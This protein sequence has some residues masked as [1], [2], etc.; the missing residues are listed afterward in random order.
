MSDEGGICFE[1]PV[2]E[3]TANLEKN[4]LEYVFPS[5]PLHPRTSHLPHLAPSTFITLKNHL[6]SFNRMDEELDSDWLMQPVLEAD[7]DSETQCCIDI[8]G[9]GSTMFADHYVTKR[10]KKRGRK[11]EGETPQD[12]PGYLHVPKRSVQHHIDVTPKPEMLGIPA[13]NIYDRS[14]VPKG[15]LTDPVTRRIACGAAPP[16]MRSAMPLTAV[17]QGDAVRPALVDEDFGDEVVEDGDDADGAEDTQLP[18][19]PSYEV[20]AADVKKRLVQTAGSPQTSPSQSPHP[21]PQR[22]FSSRGSLGHVSP[23]HAAI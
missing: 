2:I 23:P 20:A 8:G 14:A 4:F 5:L 17:M 22:T 19:P 12:T 18:P 6:F 13:T 1:I 15:S 10:K 16:S 21:S 7:Y 3:V 11:P 9:G